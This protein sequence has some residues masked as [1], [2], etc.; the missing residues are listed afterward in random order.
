MTTTLIV[1]A[2]V[3]HPQ[4]IAQII[5][6]TL[7]DPGGASYGAFAVSTTAGSYSLTLSWSSLET[8]QDINAPSGGGSRT[9]VATF[10]DQA[11]HSTSKSFN[12]ALKCP[13]ATDAICSGACTSLQSNLTACGACDHNCTTLYPSL[14]SSR[15]CSSQGKCT[16]GFSGTTLESCSAAC[17]ALGLTCTGNET[18]GYNNGG[19]TVTSMTYAC[20]M[21]PPASIMGTGASGPQTWPFDSLSCSCT[22]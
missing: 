8:V 15:A 2:V 5:G 4:G 14:T 18:V 10:Y 17:Q 6:G 22:E 1:T 7:S 16:G 9:F 11:G 12:I 3:T 21:V 13:T 19:A 20:T